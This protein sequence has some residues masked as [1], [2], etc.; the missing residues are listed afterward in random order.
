M[1]VV[2][3]YFFFQN[4]IHSY[5][6]YTFPIIMDHMIPHGN[7]LANRLAANFIREL[8]NLSRILVSRLVWDKIDILS[9]N[10]LK[11]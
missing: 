9:Q 2:F 5:W 1:C 7:K 3:P 10:L 6:F 4:L 11:R 8:D